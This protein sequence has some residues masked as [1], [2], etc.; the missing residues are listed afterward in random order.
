MVTFGSG[1]ENKVK[2]DAIQ[3]LGYLFNHWIKLVSL[4]EEIG[5]YKHTDLGASVMLQ[6]VSVISAQV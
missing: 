6:W 1:K 5:V 2:S 4:K 3:S